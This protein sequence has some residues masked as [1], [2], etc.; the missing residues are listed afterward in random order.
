MCIAVSGSALDWSLVVKSTSL[1]VCVSMPGRAAT[2]KQ[3]GGAGYC[4]NCLLR[5]RSCCAIGTPA[6]DDLV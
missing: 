4:D 3:H 2:A 5:K 6:G 1:A